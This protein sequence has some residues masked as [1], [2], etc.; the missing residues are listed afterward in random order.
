MQTRAKMGEEKPQNQYY[1]HC[2]GRNKESKAQRAHRKE[3]MNDNGIVYGLFLFQMYSVCVCMCVCEQVSM[4]LQR[5][6][7]DKYLPPSAP[8]YFLR[9]FLSEPQPYYRLHWL[10]RELHAS[11]C[12]HSPSTEP[13]GAHHHRWLLCIAE[14][15]N[16]G[17]CLCS[18]HFAH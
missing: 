16:S 2:K 7:V 6:E 3:I 9:L 15:L 10:A 1:N 5:L 8:P 14:D 11:A 18:R 12:L 4:C 17:P 13:A